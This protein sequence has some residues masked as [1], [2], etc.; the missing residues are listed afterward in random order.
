MNVRRVSLRNFTV[1]TRAEFSIPEK[2]VLVVTGQNGAGKS[3][4]VEAVA[5]AAWNK[6]LRGTSP[7]QKDKSCVVE[8]DC[9]RATVTRTRNGAKADLSFSVDGKAEQEWPTNS[10]AQEALEDVVGSWDVWRR[11]HVF[12]SAD[13]AHFTQA[14]DAE[15]K[16]L[17]EGILGLTRFDDALDDC[18][19]DLSAAKDRFA[20]A[21]TKKTTAL[22]ALQLAVQNV[23]F[24]RTT[25]GNI[26]PVT[27]PDPPG[28]RAVA[29][30]DRMLRDCETEISTARQGADR[31]ARHVGSLEANLRQIETTLDRVRHDRCPTCTQA[32]N[33]AL[34]DALASDAHK[35][36]DEINDARVSQGAAI[37]ESKGLVSELEEER[38]A[39]LRRRQARAQ[40]DR[41]YSRLVLEASANKLKVAS[42]MAD[43]QRAE[44]SRAA[45][46]ADLDAAEEAVRAAEAEVA[47]LEA[48]LQVV[49]L[50]GV[51]AHL[52]GHALGGLEQV[53]NVWLGRLGMSHLT[54]SLLPYSEK[55]TGGVTDSISIEVAGAGGGHGY[56]GA[57]SG[58]RRRLDVALLLAMSEVAGAAQGMAAGTLWF[59]EVFDALDEEG[60]EAVVS[61]LGLLAQERAVVVIT[62]ARHLVDKMPGVNKIHITKEAA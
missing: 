41:D 52:L 32:I 12:S 15:R 59:D 17:I 25:L 18:R 49:G 9:D 4:I 34:R 36:R 1:H 38:A 44:D 55:K 53:A 8:L 20:T 54:L 35:Y 3:S 62:H 42:A 6:T 60:T 31:A 43:V 47:E 29:E 19:A 5:W 16:R 23:T 10:K 30:L 46:Q 58:E 14:T 39:L 33:P 61:A 51:R 11:S 57:S 27:E 13:A 50:K 2:G 48:V 56:K 37:E 28:G 7:C 22:G 21:T 24:G 40:E 45:L 26:G